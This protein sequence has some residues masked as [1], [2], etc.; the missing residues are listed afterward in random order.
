MKLNEIEWNWMK[1]NEIRYLLLL[2]QHRVLHYRNWKPKRSYCR[3][4]LL[5]LLLL[6]HCLLLPDHSSWDCAILVVPERWEPVGDSRPSMRALPSSPVT[7]SPAL[8]ARNGV[9]DCYCSKSASLPV[10]SHQFIIQLNQF[11]HQ[12]KDINF[13]WGDLLDFWLTNLVKSWITF[14][15]YKIILNS[16]S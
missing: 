9:L 5:L 1:L 12:I 13:F 10:K 14:L 11:I 3:A 7:N 2:D 15:R 4:V 6:L 16:I 8:W